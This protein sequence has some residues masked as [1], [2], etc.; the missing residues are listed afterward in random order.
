MFQID[1]KT[2][3]VRRELIPFVLTLNLQTG[4]EGGLQDAEHLEAGKERHGGRGSQFWS[5]TR[6]GSI[7]DNLALK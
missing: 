2:S 3:L 7:F 5:K 1:R 4:Q 6:A